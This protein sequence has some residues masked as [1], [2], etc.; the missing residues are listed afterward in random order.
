MKNIYV[1]RHCKAEGQAPDARLTDD[2]AQQAEQLAQFFSDKNIDSIISSPFERAC[3][4]ITPLA[5][6]LGLEISTDERLAERVLSGKNH[7][8]WRDMLRKTYDD[9]D[10]CYEGGESSN[11]AMSR[12]SNVVLE[13]LDRASQ[14]IVL[15]SHGNLISLL[16]K[17]YD[18]RYGYKEWESLS[19]PDVFHLSFLED[20]PNIRRV[21]GICE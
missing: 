4:T 14:N 1:V 15:V 16:L 9:L 8:D 5:E 6:K 19:N 12:A 20:K 18:D 11:T 21:W 3:R 10:L 7:A 17:Y 2:G 13:A